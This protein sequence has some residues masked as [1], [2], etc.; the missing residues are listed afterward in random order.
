M[1]TKQGSRAGN[2][3]LT[4]VMPFGTRVALKLPSDCI[5]GGR[6]FGL[7]SAACVLGWHLGWHPT[8]R[9]SVTGG[10]LCVGEQLL[11][12]TSSSNCI[13]KTWD[14]KSGLGRK[15]GAPVQCL[16]LKYHLALLPPNPEGTNAQSCVQGK[17]FTSAGLRSNLNLA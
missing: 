15:R 4:S 9:N 11:I 10:N 16:L 1:F 5:T 8:P 3:N 14:A 17:S 6:S 7:V 2:F 13:K 12:Y